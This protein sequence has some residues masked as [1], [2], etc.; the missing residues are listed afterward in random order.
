MV[1]RRDLSL[2]LVAIGALAL[3]GR[4]HAQAPPTVAAASDLQFALDAIAQAFTAETGQRVSLVFGSSGTLTRQISDGAP[5]EVFLS[6]DED[7][8]DAAGGCRADAE[9]PA[10]CTR[11]A[12]SCSSRRADPR[13]P[14]RAARA[15]L[16][17]CW[18]RAAEV[19]R[20]AIANPERG[21]VR[22]RGRG[23]APRRAGCGTR[24][25]PHLVLGDN[26]SQ[27]AQFATTGNAVGRHHRV[28]ARARARRSQARGTY[29]LIPE[30]L[31]S[32][33]SP[34]HGAVE[35]R[36]SGRRSSS[37]HYLQGGRG[38]GDSP[39]HG[40]ARATNRRRWTGQRFAFPCGSASGRS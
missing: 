22:P 23:G 8:L 1:R 38:S 14:R 6:A 17:R 10:S 36:R 20:F 19:R 15:G 13:W 12:A 40:F 24:C 5:F 26:I 7:V 39:K 21:A 28:L 27:A 9:M 11:S 37:T 35:A 2:W 16:A 32:A 18:R 30:S 34:A 25:S 31:T 4:L 29:A 3:P 33:A